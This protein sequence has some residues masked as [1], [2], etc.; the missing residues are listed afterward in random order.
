[1]D[2]DYAVVNPDRLKNDINGRIVYNKNGQIQV[3]IT[4]D[5]KAGSVAVYAYISKINPAIIMP[6][7]KFKLS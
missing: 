5:V 1:M 6:E 2:D 3:I 7:M 4:E